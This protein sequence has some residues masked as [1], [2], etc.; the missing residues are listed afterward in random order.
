MR[1]GQTKDRELFEWQHLVAWLGGIMCALV[2]FVGGWEIGA[3][4]L[5]LRH[6][7]GNFGF[8]ILIATGLISLGALIAG[9]WWRLGK[10]LL[11]RRDGLM[12]I[13]A[14]ILFVL[15]LVG[16]VTEVLDTLFLYLVGGVLLSGLVLA[17]VYRN[18]KSRD[19]PGWHDFLEWLDSRKRFNL[20]FFIVMFLALL[21]NNL[22]LVW[23]MEAGVGEKL[24]ILLGRFFTNAFVVWVWY[25]F[26]EL[27][28]RSAPK[29]FRWTPWLALGLVPLLVIVDQWLGLMWNRTLLGV[30]NSLTSSGRLNLAMELETSGMNVGP[31][32]AWLIVIGVFVVAML[33]AG[34][35]WLVSRR[36]HTRLSIGL[37]VVLMMACWLAVV[38]EQGVGAYWKKITAWQD[39]RKAF[40]LHI[41]IFEPPQG[42]G[43][44]HVSF[45]DGLAVNQGDVPW[46]ANKP[47]VYIFMLE[48]L[49]SDALKPG[50]APFLSDFRDSECQALEGTWAA[51]N[52]THLSW[53]AFFHSRVPIFWREALEEI[54]DREKFAG[55]IPFQ[56]LKQ[57]GYEIEVRAVCDFGYKDFGFSNFGYQQNLAYVL[58]QAGVGDELSKFN[59]AERERVT[60]EKLKQSVIARPGGGG[61]YF[62]ALDSPHYN[63]YWHE[64]FD[65]PFKDYDENTRFPMNPDKAEV[66]RVVNRYWNSVAWVDFQIKGFCDFLKSEGRYD[67]SII[68]I[69]GDHGEEF[70]ERG[71]WFHCSSLRVEQ[72][73]VPILIKWPSSMGRGPSQ[74]DVNH[75]DVMPSLMY[76]LGMPEATIRG[77]A[78]RNLLV[79][80]AGQTSISTTAYAGKS[81]ET[82][83][84]HRGGYE[85]VFYWE[86]YWESQV[87]TDIVLE[88]LTGPD[89][90]VVKLRNAKQYAE[91]LK[92]LFPDA[93]KRF[94]KSLQVVKD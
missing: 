46:L 17:V 76:A 31:A 47:D 6:G 61:L 5:P 83:V 29:Y 36:Y 93:F 42:L 20:V 87:P 66:Q 56:Q 41:G 35:C 81:G 28:M 84:L 16:L 23:S 62:T 64:D 9:Y 30:V 27:V 34:G 85:A 38:A 75:I 82:M 90:K 24:S 44:Y 10:W 12:S 69:T 77:M 94:F 51:S 45:H 18:V 22:G 25:L 54:P 74:T 50:V 65:P 32:G 7:A 80:Q 4:H 57:A 43:S 58:E 1:L 52:A 53:F 60:M 59:V 26:A 73:G 8:N 40:D 71:S 79:K 92:K 15:G 88:K 14:V 78:G 37:A 67:E 13:T 70:Q 21:S 72:I 11:G 89:G 2:P 48:S 91:E 39:E 55:A 3:T 63:Y 33:M 19:W 86:D 49:R 68:I